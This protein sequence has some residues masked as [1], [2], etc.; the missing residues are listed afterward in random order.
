MLFRSF[1][2]DFPILVLGCVPIVGLRAT[3]SCGAGRS[4][5]VVRR[6][7]LMGRG[8]TVDLGITV[9]RKRPV[10]GTLDEVATAER[11]LV[12]KTCLDD[13]PDNCCPH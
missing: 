7:L 12:R 9:T 1:S 10:L 8:T 13:E 5:L 11:S 6:S 2:L 3:L 4:A